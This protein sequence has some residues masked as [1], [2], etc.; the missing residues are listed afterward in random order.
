MDLLLGGLLSAVFLLLSV[1][2]FRFIGRFAPPL[3]YTQPFVMTG[4]SGA[5]VALLSSS[6]GL[7]F[8][9]CGIIT[10]PVA[11]ATGYWGCR[12]MLDEF[13]RDVRF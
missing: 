12:L 10:L 2:A 4:L 8:V 9:V 6:I 7:P 1:P 5:A 11:L 3:L 13:L